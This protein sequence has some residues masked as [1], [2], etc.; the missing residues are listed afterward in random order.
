M[1]EKPKFLVFVKEKEQVE[2][3]NFHV[4]DT[5]NIGVG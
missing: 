2:K 3:S 4:D 1:L 5:L